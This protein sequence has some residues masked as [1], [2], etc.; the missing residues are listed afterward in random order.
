M[1]VQEKFKNGFTYA[2]GIE[3]WCKRFLS[4]YSNTKLNYT[5]CADFAIADWCGSKDVKETYQRVKKQWLNDYEAF[6]EVAMSLNLLAWANDQLAKQGF[7]GREEFIELYSK[8]YY[9]AR[10]DFY[11]KYADN[12]EAKEYFFEMTD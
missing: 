1:K 6:T 2:A 3:E 7:E 5:F 9:K 12:T 4:S 11:D 10:D 8:L